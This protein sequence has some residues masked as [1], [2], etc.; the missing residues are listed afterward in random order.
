MPSVY[1][2]R[3]R[4]AWILAHRP[5][6]PAEPD[7]EAPRGVFLEEERLRSGRVAPT[8]VVLLT[9]RE[10]PWRCLMCDLWKDTT[11]RSVPP[12]AIPRQLEVAAE[13]WR[14]AGGVPEQV[15]L[16]NHGSFF[17][18]AAI[19][20]ADYPAIAGRLAFAA[21][22]VVESHPRLVGDRARRLRDLLAGDLEV[23]MG[24]ETAHP[25]VLERLNKRFD[26]SHFARA[27]EF[28]TR[29][30]IAVRAFVL[31]KPPFMTEAEGL[32]W[33]VKSA[34][35]AFACGAGVVSLIP[36][37]TGNGA[38]EQLQSAG[39]FA[40]PKLATLE[41][42]QQA[43]LALNQGRVFA[44]TWGLEPFST[45]PRCLE[46]RRRRLQTVNLTQRDEPPV[47]CP[48]CDGS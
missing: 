43:A 1:P 23:A 6:R 22:V 31:V 32:E 26:L 37:R 12:G 39:E 41:Q 29:E 48:D 8:G 3:D 46:A 18:V 19:P 15:K 34:E 14:R 27:C 7:P 9:N 28:L 2:Q 44:D 16:Y 13:T 45:C 5:A 35:F 20:P 11:T 21:N 10:C 30:G 33:A 25:S 40:P 36:T 17:D 24:L 42:A 47:A 38:M 4:T